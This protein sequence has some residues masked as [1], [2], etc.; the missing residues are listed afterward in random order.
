VSK[1]IEDDL[2]LRV[3]KESD[4]CLKRWRSSIIIAG[5][6]AEIWTVYLAKVTAT[7]TWSDPS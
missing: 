5:S 4:G 2:E 3:G 1:E 6:Q 7:P